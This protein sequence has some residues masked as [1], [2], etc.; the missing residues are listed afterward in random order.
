MKNKLSYFRFNPR[1]AMG[2]E[3]AFA[4]SQMGGFFLL[5]LPAPSSI[6]ISASFFVT[7]QD[8][9]RVCV[10]FVSIFWVVIDAMI[11]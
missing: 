6:P 8:F 3:V 4:S 7:I 11:A 5:S 2:Y 9:I 1:A 10:F